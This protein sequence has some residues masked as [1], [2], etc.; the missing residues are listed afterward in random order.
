MDSSQLDSQSDHQTFH[1]IRL[2]KETVDRAKNGSC[3]VG[4]LLVHDD[5]SME[6]ED[7]LSRKSYQLLRN[8]PIGATR[9]QLDTPPSSQ[10]KSTSGGDGQSMGRVSHINAINSIHL[11]SSNE[12]D[13]LK[14]SLQKDEAIHLGKVKTSTFLAVPKAGVTSVSTAS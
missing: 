1:L 6:F 10:L 13:L 9:N 4:T 8:T 2:P 3:L 12:S 5:G 11:A 7:N 14:I